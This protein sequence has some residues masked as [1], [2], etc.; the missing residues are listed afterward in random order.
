MKTE[1]IIYKI[2]HKPTGLYF[3]PV[4]GRFD[5]DK[6]NLSS[7]GNHYQHLYMV[8][9]ILK[10]ECQEA[11]INEAQIKRY[12]C[13]VKKNAWGRVF[14]RPEDFIIKRFILKEI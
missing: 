12:G 7:K 8:Q 4:K 10:E 13:A 11:Q 14:C 6:T 5:Y 3:C 9:K 2:Y 1:D